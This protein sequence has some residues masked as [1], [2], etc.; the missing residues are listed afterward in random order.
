MHDW[1][2]GAEISDVGGKRLVGHLAELDEVGFDVQD[3]VVRNLPI[4]CEE[5]DS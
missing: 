2:R 5:G 3:Q 4:V 1:R